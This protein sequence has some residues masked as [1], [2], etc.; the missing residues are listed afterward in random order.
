MANPPKTYSSQEAY[1]MGMDAR[2]V[3]IIKFNSIPPPPP[4]NPPI[5]R[6]TEYHS[7]ISS[8][9]KDMIS[10]GN[11]NN[12]IT[13]QDTNIRVLPYNFIPVVNVK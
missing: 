8:I 5:N 7:N 10:K 1:R 12:V 6:Q 3:S 13:S 9:N 11:F 2:P 4:T